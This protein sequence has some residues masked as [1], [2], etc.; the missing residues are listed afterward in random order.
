MSNASPDVVKISYGFVFS[1]MALA[2][3]P[4]RYVISRAQDGYPPEEMAPYKFASPAKNSM[5]RMPC[6]ELLDG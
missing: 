6:A 4:W 3:S 5:K 1:D 2:S